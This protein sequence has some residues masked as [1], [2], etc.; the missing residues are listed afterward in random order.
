M[1]SLS[2]IETRLQALHP[3][4]IDLDLS[5]IERLLTR[6]R[7]TC[8]YHGLLHGVLCRLGQPERSLPRVVHVAGTNGKGSTVAMVRA[9]LESSGLRV[10]AYTSPH[11]VDLSESFVVGRFLRVSMLQYLCCVRIHMPMSFVFCVAG[12]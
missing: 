3:N 6:C 8:L 5:R 11:L 4:T 1:T 2:S 9:A 7:F 10:H 12:T